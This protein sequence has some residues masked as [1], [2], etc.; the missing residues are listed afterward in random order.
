MV[1]YT[2]SG[3]NRYGTPEDLSRSIQEMTVT[4]DRGFSFVVDR[5]DNL[6]SDNIYDISAALKRQTDEGLIPEYDSY[7][8][9]KLCDAAIDNGS[10][11]SGSITK[12]NAFQS[13][14]AGITYLG[15]HNVPAANRICFCSYSFYSYLSQDSSF[16]RYG[17]ASQ[18]MLSRGELG[19]VDG[20]KIVKVPSTRLPAGAAFLLVHKDAATAPRQLSEYKIHDD[21]PGISGTLCEAR[22]IYDCFVFNEKRDAIYYH[23]GQSGLKDL[24]LVVTPNGI[25]TVRLV[26]NSLLSADTNTRYYITAA[27]KSALPTVTYNTA[28][29]LTSEAWKTAAKVEDTSYA[30]VSV[31]TGHTYMLVVELD[32]NNKPVAVGTKLINVTT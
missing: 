25:G 5:G 17:D 7:C 15:D 4:R 2:R 14:M 27:T 6:Q 3:L 28:I 22:F 10:Y 12:N 13:F 29:D 24:P 26:I 8:F 9:R 1:D 19:E 30:T 18:E 31:T 32:A 20:V 23:G 16:I 21:P 11:A